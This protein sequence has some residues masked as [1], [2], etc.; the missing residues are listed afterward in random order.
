MKS[1]YAI[2][3]HLKE[4]TEALVRVQRIVKMIYRDPQCYICEILFLKDAHE[5]EFQARLRPVP[6][7][8]EARIMLYHLNGIIN[9]G[10]L[11]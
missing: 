4:H 11:I 8:L 1:L 9:G 6:N 3:S 5:P 10:G 2:N 7:N